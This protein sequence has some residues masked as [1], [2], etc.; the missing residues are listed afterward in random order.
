MADVRSVGPLG[1][2]D[3]GQADNQIRRIA[4]MFDSLGGGY[5][6]I[7]E[8]NVAEPACRAIACCQISPADQKPQPVSTAIGRQVT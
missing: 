4:E 3:A 5:G 8:G 1:G 6:V 2:E 7:A